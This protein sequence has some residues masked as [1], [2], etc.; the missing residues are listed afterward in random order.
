MGN[1]KE[2]NIK[3]R[4][5]YFFDDIINIEDFDP[6]LLKVDEK[7]YKNI[8]IYYIGY[9]TIKDY[10]YVKIK[11]VNPLS[12]IISEVDGHIKEKN[13]NKYLIFNSVDKNKEVLKK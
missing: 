12:L 4:T 6:N 1:I 7:S 2:I 8:N 5:Y 9:I 10:D 11:S 13:G 3:N